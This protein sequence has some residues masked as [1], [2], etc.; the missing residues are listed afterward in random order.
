MAMA[1]P[2]NIKLPE[3]LLAAVRK[4]AVAQNKSVAEVLL[5]ALHAHLRD[6][7]WREMI[8]QARERTAAL[9]IREEDVNESISQ[10][11]REYP[12]RTK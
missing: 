3:A 5:E 1:E 11:R 4:I 2:Q 9:G 8:E 10:S 7:E 6:R 12:Q